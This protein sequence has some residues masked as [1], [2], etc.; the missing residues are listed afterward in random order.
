MNLPCITQNLVQ[1]AALVITNCEEVLTGSSLTV[2]FT[3]RPDLPADARVDLWVSYDGGVTYIDVAPSVLATAG[4]IT[5]NVPI[6][7]N[8]QTFQACLRLGNAPGFDFPNLPNTACCNFTQATLQGALK[9]A[10]SRFQLQPRSQAFQERF[11]CTTEDVSTA[12]Q[13]GPTILTASTQAQAQAAINTMNPGEELI[14][15]PGNY[16]N[17]VLSSISGSD[18]LKK[19]ISGQSNCLGTGPATSSNQIMFEAT[20]TNFVVRRMADGSPYGGHFARIYGAGNWFIDNRILRNR[21]FRMTPQGTKTNPTTRGTKILKNYAEGNNADYFLHLFS[22]FSV[23]DGPSVYDLEYAGNTISKYG[24]ADGGAKAITDVSWY[25]S[26]GISSPGGEIPAAET[27]VVGH[28]NL[29]LDCLGEISTVKTRRQSM[30]HN[31]AICPDGWWS[32]RSAD[33]HDFYA[34][35]I[36]SRYA[37]PTYSQAGRR[38]DSFYN[39]DITTGST[40]AN[41][42]EFSHAASEG[43][44]AVAAGGR[45][46]RRIPMQDNDWRFNWYLNENDVNAATIMRML[47]DATHEPNFPTQGNRYQENFYEGNPSEMQFYGSLPAAAGT[48]AD[49]NARNPNSAKANQYLAVNGQFPA[50]INMPQTTPLRRSDINGASHSAGCPDWIGPDGELIALS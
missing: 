1:T 20:G 2:E 50:T 24:T 7:T 38:I 6:P 17:L 14:L 3:A 49:W 41:G 42:P 47:I 4:V 35:V 45:F 46:T 37:S 30:H 32:H 28:H 43:S 15:S 31:L 33:D 9:T 26:S 8:G 25:W 39:V 22:P 12:I 19:V 34:N 13:V 36:Y 5:S 44:S 48:L 23:Q 29:F 21:A 11:G 18:T 40:P 27:F 16:G 10:F